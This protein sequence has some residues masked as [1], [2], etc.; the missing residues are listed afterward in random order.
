MILIKEEKM[1]ECCADCP[2]FD[3]EYDSCNVI[4][5]INADIMEERPEDCPL[6]E[7]VTCKDCKYN[8]ENVCDIDDAQVEDDYFCGGA[9]RR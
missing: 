7:V 2:V 4:G 3:C 1:P 8:C 5:K 6:V 9:E